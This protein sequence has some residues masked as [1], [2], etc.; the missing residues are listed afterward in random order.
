MTSILGNTRRADI[1]FHPRGNI[2]ITARV[3]KLLDLHCGDI[4]DIYIEGGEYYLYLKHRANTV[5]GR[6]EATLYPTSRRVKKC[7]NLRCHSRRLCVAM[8]EACR[9]SEILRLPVGEPVNLR[10]TTAVPIITR[11]ALNNIH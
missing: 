3:S 2:D 4:I 9:S 5:A 11:W 10:G 1:T 8:Q 7:H 6:H